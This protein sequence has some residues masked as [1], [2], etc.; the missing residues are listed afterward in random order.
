MFCKLCEKLY[1]VSDLQG[2]TSTMAPLCYYP[3]PQRPFEVV[4]MD[5]SGPYNLSNNR[6]KYI[7]V[8]CCRLTRYLILVAT[9]DRTA[10]SV[11]EALYYGIIL[12]YSA[13]QVLVS[14]Q[15]KEFHAELLK[16]LC[17]LCSIRQAYITTYHPSSNEIVERPMSIISPILRILT[18]DHKN[19]WNKY[20]PLVESCVNSGYSTTLNDNPFYAL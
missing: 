10:A 16:Q 2:L 18:H 1:S 6:F 13:P 20:L 5:F 14:D 12:K 15:A 17:K 19:T 8:M 9:T 4:H 7:L 11:A 3:Q